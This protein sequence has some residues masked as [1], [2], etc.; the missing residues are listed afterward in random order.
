[1]GEIRIY[2]AKQEPCRLCN[3]RQGVLLPLCQDGDCEPFFFLV[4]LECK[5]KI[6][7]KIIPIK[8]EM[9]AGFFYCPET[10]NDLDPSQGQATRKERE[11]K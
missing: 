7:Y 6:P 10:P 5:D 9:G 8:V 1:M 3:L 4:C 11:R 2:E